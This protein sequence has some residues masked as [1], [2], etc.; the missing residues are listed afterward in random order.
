MLHELFKVLK[1]LQKTA[2][3]QQRFHLFSTSQ[4]INRQSSIS[5]SFCLTDAGGSER[6]MHFEIGKLILDNK[7]VLPVFIISHVVYTY[8]QPF[9]TS[10]PSKCVLKHI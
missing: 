7:N 9:T 3:R 5:G 4:S 6:V 2:K 10:G 1:Q 8:Y